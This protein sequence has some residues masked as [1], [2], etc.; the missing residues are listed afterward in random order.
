[1]RRQAS[2]SPV[3]PGVRAPIRRKKATPD[4][5]TRCC[6]TQPASAKNTNAS[7]IFEVCV[8]AGRSLCRSAAK[9][10][11]RRP[12]SEGRLRSDRDAPRTAA[13]RRPVS[14]RP[15]G[16]PTSRR[17]GVRS[18]CEPEQT[19]RRASPS[20]PG[21]RARGPRSVQRFQR[22]RPRAQSARH[23]AQPAGNKAA[24]G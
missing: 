4:V 18:E 9:T 1:M 13:R 11:D 23:K 8:V 19:P 14:P 24:D 5:T 15:A 20:T 17:S 6:L 3:V 22:R 7:R 21:T 12:M 2:S 16:R 10:R